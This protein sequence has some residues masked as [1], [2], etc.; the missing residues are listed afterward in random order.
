MTVGVLCAVRG[1][2]EAV[3]V[4]AVDGTGGRLTV[5]RR[6]AD[7]AELLAAAEAGLGRI[8]VVSV[9]LPMLDRDAVAALHRSGVRLVGLGEAGAPW[10]S[11]RITA[12]GADLVVDTPDDAAGAAALV[13]DVVEVLGRTADDVGQPGATPTDGH[14]RGP[15][16]D[17][18]HDAAGVDHLGD[19]P[20][21][22]QLGRVVAVWGPTGAP[23]R[24][25]VA[26][27]LAAELALLGG[28]T[29]LVDADTYGGTI[30]QAVGLLDEAPGLAAA[31]RAAGQGGLDT[32]LLARLSP[33]IS[34]DLRVLSGISRADRWPELPSAALDVVWTVARTLAAWTVIDCGFC[35]EQDEVLSYDTRAPRRNAATLSALGDADEVVVVGA[36]DPLGIQRLVRALGDL[37]QLGL[38]GRTT[39]VV[40][41]VRASVAGPRPGEAITAAL[42]RYA[43]V[44]APQLVPED[45][46]ALDAALLEARLLHE[47]APTS[48]ARRAIAALA[49]RLGDRPSR[50]SVARPARRS[51]EPAALSEPR[52]AARLAG[53]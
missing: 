53:A 44:S 39:V 49:L 24:T 12:L 6:C 18:P 47:L 20:R 8:A 23:G 42:D 15:R 3:I 7:L 21:R 4:Q 1:S 37:A 22:T 9:D 51:R 46:P 34:P 32:E 40:N 36:G 48:P 26:V 27:N 52:D 30:A 28:H 33:L 17:P 14:A 25:T 19:P 45:R 29:L 31:A 10:L 43:G 16:F 50:S 2:A 41:Q 5:T 11:E 13:R 38:V 35:I